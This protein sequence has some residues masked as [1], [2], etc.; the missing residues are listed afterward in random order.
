M[1]FTRMMLIE[2]IANIE[3]M[4][5]CGDAL[6]LGHGPEARWDH[7]VK[8]KG[9]AMIRRLWETMSLLLHSKGRRTASTGAARLDSPVQ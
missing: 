8:D 5:Q 2:I 9:S 7:L 6:T 1:Q 4:R 3:F